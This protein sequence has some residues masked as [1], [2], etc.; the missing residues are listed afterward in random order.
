MSGGH[1]FLFTAFTAAPCALACSDYDYDDNGGG[2]VHYG[3]E[4]HYVRCCLRLN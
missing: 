2:V 4:D 3:A 1:A